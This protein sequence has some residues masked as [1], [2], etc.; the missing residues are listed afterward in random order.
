MKY[1]YLLINLFTILVPMARSFD[2]RMPFYKQWRNYFPGMIF[3][4]L[5]FLVWDYFKT[6]YGVWSFND[7]Y[8]LGIRFF[9]LPLEEVL[10]FFTV[11]YA[12]TFIYE[13]VRYFQQRRVF[14]D[15]TRYVIQLLSFIMIVASFQVLHKAYTFTVLFILGLVIPVS[16][17]VL[18]GRRLDLFLQMYAISL[19]PMFVVNGLL[20]GLPVVLYNDTQNLGIRI[21]TIPVEDFIYSAIMLLMNVALYEWLRERNAQKP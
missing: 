6:K 5:F 21:G 14:P 9:G 19:I 20:T 18:D 11:P 1:T 10:F 7:K 4:A 12:C 17:R 2:S 8:I 16:L 15:N 13:C 3:T